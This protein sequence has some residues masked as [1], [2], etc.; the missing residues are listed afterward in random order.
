MLIS[1][2]LHLSGEGWCRE[3]GRREGGCTT[4]EIEVKEKTKQVHIENERELTGSWI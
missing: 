3:T 1:Q 2:P 4:K